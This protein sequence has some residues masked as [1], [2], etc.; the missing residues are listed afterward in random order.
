MSMLSTLYHSS[1]GKKFM[2]GLTGLFL[3]SFLVV[4]VSGNLL[5]F[6]KDN[7]ASFDAFAEFM[8]TNVIIRTM[9]IVLFAGFIG[10][11]ITGTI[12]WAKNRSARPQKYV[13]NE[14]AA[15]S[16]WMSRTMFLTGSIIFFFLV[17]H[18]RTFWFVS[19]F[20]AEEN[21]SMYEIVRTSLADPAYAALYI[22]AVA[23]LAF[24]L[25][26]GFQSAFQTFG[27]K[28]QKYAPIIRLVAMIFWLLIP[29]AF[30]SMPVYFLMNP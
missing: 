24:H 10:H 20:Q 11:I 6:A 16:T 19:R 15:N 12:V 1:V 4:H 22:V 28:H 2:M 13:A 27:I 23:L 5:L 17:I 21:P 26:H 3:C 25:R 9:E 30:M 7:G 8:A 29:L 18:V 14:A